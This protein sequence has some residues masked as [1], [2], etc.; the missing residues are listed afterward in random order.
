M[1]DF[2]GVDVKDSII[3]GEKNHLIA[4]LGLDNIVVVQTKDATL[5]CAKDK[6]EGVR[7][8]VELAGNKAALR[9]YL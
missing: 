1:G 5:V 7:A 9:R 6:A 2:L 3:L 4:C 8:L